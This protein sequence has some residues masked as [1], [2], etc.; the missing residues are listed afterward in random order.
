MRSQPHR[1]ADA[2]VARVRDG[3][4]TRLVAARTPPFHLLLSVA[5]DMTAIDLI[6][7]DLVHVD[8]ELLGVNAPIAEARRFVAAW[9]ARTRHTAVL[10]MRTRVFQLE[11]VQWPVPM[12]SGQARFAT[13]DDAPLLAA[14][15]EAFRAEAVPNDPRTITGADVAAGWL[16][17]PEPVVWLW[18]DEEG[19]PV[20]MA[21][22]GGKT[23]HGVRIGGVYTPPAHRRRGY[24]SAL[25]ASASQGELDRGR[26]MCFL[27]ADLANGTSNR[28]YQA[29]G[30]RPV[31]D[32]EIYRFVPGHGEGLP[33]S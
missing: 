26:T 14:W 5:G 18:I 1:F 12:A 30:Y 20:S 10:D 22:A 25:V 7:D 33:P 9:M 13:S 8:E 15:F 29:I 4:E 32:V 24:A 17:R 23:P 31:G 6:A 28:I 2:Y 16:S 3:D 11:K 21:V 19:E 27:D